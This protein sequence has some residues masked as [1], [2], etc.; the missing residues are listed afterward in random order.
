[1]AVRIPEE[2]ERR[3]RAQPQQQPQT[4]AIDTIL[5]RD[6]Q[7]VRTQVHER[8]QRLGITGVEYLGEEAKLEL[9]TKSSLVDL[10]RVG[11]ISVH[12]PKYMSIKLFSYLIEIGIAQALLQ[13]IGTTEGGLCARAL[14]ADHDFASGAGEQLCTFREWMQP[15][16]TRGWSNRFPHDTNIWSEENRW[17]FKYNMESGDV[18]EEP[19]GL[20]YR[21]MYSTNFN[22]HYNRKVL[23]L[24]G[25]AHGNF[26]YER[27][28]VNGIQISRGD[29]RVVDISDMSEIERKG[30]LYYQNPVLVKAAD[31]LNIHFLLKH[32]AIGHSD[33]LQPLGFTI[34]NFGNHMSG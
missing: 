30:I 5:Q 10:N 9:L 20:R 2:Q 8:V 4:T 27:C 16:P 34:E 7:D 22:T 32:D 23:V 18:V 31:E 33:R 1:M 24:L 11:L 28:Y 3:I 19:N 13:V 26:P 15:Q 21:N 14:M 12:K 25:W 6:M 17:M 29:V